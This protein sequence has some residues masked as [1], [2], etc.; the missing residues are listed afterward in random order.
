MGYL[1]G[2]VS[3]D[4]CLR[5]GVADILTGQDYEPPVQET[6]IFSRL[7]HIRRVQ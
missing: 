3:D 5:I 1:G 4:Q 2:G 6:H 7:Q